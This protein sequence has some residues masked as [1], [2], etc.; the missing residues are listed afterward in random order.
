MIKQAD[1]NSYIYFVVTNQIINGEF[2][3]IHGL[4]QTIF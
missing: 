4:S 3:G 2:V 1:F